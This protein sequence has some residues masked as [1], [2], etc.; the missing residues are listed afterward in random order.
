MSSSSSDAPPK[1]PAE[2]ERL[3]FNDWLF[4]FEIFLASKEIVQMPVV[5]DVVDPNDV[6]VYLGSDLVG[7][8]DKASIDKLHKVRLNGMKA[9]S[10][11]TNALHKEQ[12]E[13]V[14]N[15][16]PLNAYNV[17]N[18][19][20]KSYG[21]IKSSNNA[22]SLLNKLSNITKSP[23]ET[24]HHYFAR[25]ESII[26]DLRT[27][28]PSHVTNDNMRK[29]YILNG[30]KDDNDYKF[31]TSIITQVDIDGKMTVDGLKQHLI[32]QEDRKAVTK[33]STS[34]THKPNEREHERALYSHRSSQYSHRVRQH[35]RHSNARK[36]EDD[37]HKHNDRSHSRSR[38]ITRINVMIVTMNHAVVLTIVTV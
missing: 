26:I 25:I 13:I 32:D 3:E 27:V 18:A 11:I 21:V 1:F 36:H 6:T 7:K 10:Y 19:L 15:T 24:M 12:R 17:L 2:N 37:R 29:M 28:D 4:S 23:N 20:K 8:N 33:Q 22:L 30:L 14:R 16:K 34:S 38:R 35:H 5:P 31:T 9:L